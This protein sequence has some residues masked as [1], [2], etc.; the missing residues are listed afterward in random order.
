M[1]LAISVMLQWPEFGGPATRQDGQV[2]QHQIRCSQCA[3]V[4]LTHTSMVTSSCFAGNTM[5]R[6]QMNAASALGLKRRAH[7]KLLAVA[8]DLSL[9]VN[10]VIGVWID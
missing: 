7:G 10:C 3:I 2:Y 1:S 6:D 4:P 8:G 9:H 5:P